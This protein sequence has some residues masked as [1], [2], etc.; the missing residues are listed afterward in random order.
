MNNVILNIID[1]LPEQEREE[2]FLYLEE[3]ATT[4]GFSDDDTL[5]DILV[6]KLCNW[7]Y[8]T[9]NKDI[10]I[11]KLINITGLCE[12]IPDKYKQWESIVY[13][14]IFFLLMEISQKRVAK[15][16]VKQIMLD[17]N[18]NN[19]S[20]VPTA[21]RLVTLAS[22]IPVLYKLGQ[23]IARNPNVDESF[24]KWLVCLENGIITT[25]IKYFRSILDIELHDKTNG[26]IELDLEP[27]SEAS[28]AAVTAFSYYR[29]SNSAQ[30][31]C[32]FKIVKPGARECLIED[33]D[34]LNKLAS[35]YTEN[36]ERYGVFNLNFMGIIKDVCDLLSKEVDLKN[37]QENMFYAKDFYKSE[38]DLE[39]PAVI[40]S[41][42]TNNIT[43]MSLIDG[44]KVTDAELNDK[45]RTNA[46]R[47]IAKG[48]LCQSLFSNA[49]YSIFHGDPHAGNILAS[50][51][52]RGNVKIAFI[53]WSLAGYLNK[54][55]RHCIIWIAIGVFLDSKETIKKAI[56]PLIVKD[57][58]NKNNT[59]NKII[60]NALEMV[61][62]ENNTD[63]IERALLIVDTLVKQG[64]IFP[65]ELLIFRKSVF[66][67]KGVISSIEPGFN[68]NS[69]FIEYVAGILIQEVPYRF[70]A[71]FLPFTDNYENYKSLLVNSD[72]FYVSNMLLFKLLCSLNPLYR[73]K[74]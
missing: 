52:D 26:T 42:S 47:T 63:L 48:V 24:S 72:I 49:S 11:K 58:E 41:L 30:Q 18:R 74:L 55:I 34:I 44:V 64:I 21:L 17:I 66:T 12:C 27:L 16:I 70:N 62:C 28:V 57:N 40:P 60:D 37:E 45:Q 59:L 23:V 68:M 32:V 69:F 1:F 31:R 71:A 5:D 38:N 29:E 19:D 6:D 65:K 9:D 36:R 51:D 22:K 46:C 25:D 56:L 67:I 14:G 3:L 10:F 13:D 2:I 73:T 35:F 7:Q 50:V 8:F 33:I 61:N 15:L 20:E 4:N 54:H 43:T 53:D 39:V